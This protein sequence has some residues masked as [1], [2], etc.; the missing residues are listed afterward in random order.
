MSPAKAADIFEKLK[1]RVSAESAELDVAEKVLKAWA[2][3]HPEASDF[4]GRVR[5]RRS[6]RRQLD[7]G[8]VKAHL[9][10]EQVEQ[11]MRVSPTVGLELVHPAVRELGEVAQEPVHEATCEG[12]SAQVI[13][14]IDLRPSLEGQGWQLG[15]GRTRC[16]ACR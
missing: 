5:F 7:Q 2:A 13:A 15:Q 11:F 4:E 10:P 8:A 6:S 9:G 12:C 3:E 14:S 1:A 16:P